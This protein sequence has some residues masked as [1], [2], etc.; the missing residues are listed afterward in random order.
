[1]IKKGIFRKNLQA[2]ILYYRLAI[3]LSVTSLSSSITK[4]KY[5]EEGVYLIQKAGHLYICLEGRYNSVGFVPSIIFTYYLT[6]MDVT[7]QHDNDG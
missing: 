6:L 7:F 4:T 5:L 2:K 3:R 1:M